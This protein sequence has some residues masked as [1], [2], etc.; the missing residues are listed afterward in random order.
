MGWAATAELRANGL[1]QAHI[2]G[3]AGDPLFINIDI[4][5]DIDVP[6]G[7]FTWK[8]EVRA[9]L[10]SSGDA[11]AT[12]SIDD[13]GTTDTELHITLT[14]ADT[15]P[16]KSGCNNHFDVRSTGASPVVP[17]TCARGVIVPSPTVTRP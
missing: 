7:D 10:Q 5:A 1:W 8:S 15:T 17:F 14:L 2:V 16:L 12:F 3:D 6:W 4:V 9:N 11:T 13:N